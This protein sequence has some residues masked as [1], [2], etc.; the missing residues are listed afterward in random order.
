MMIALCAGSAA[1]ESGRT[2]AISGRVL[3]VT[4]NRMPMACEPLPCPAREIAALP[5]QGVDV[6]AYS[7]F[8]KSKNF[9]AKTDQKGRYLIS[10]VPHGKYVLITLSLKKTVSLRAKSRRVN[11]LEILTVN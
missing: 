5:A 1:A 10:G 3:R 8:D 2:S 4:E 11:F 9:S 7:V 6:V